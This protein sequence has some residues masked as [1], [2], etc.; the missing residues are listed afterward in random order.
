MGD[1]LLQ[2][3]ISCFGGAPPMRY[4]LG[5]VVPPEDVAVPAHFLSQLP[6]VSPHC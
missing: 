1:L 3:L 6:Q 5:K 4:L 2:R